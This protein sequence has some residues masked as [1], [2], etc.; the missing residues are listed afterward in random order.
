MSSATNGERENHRPPGLSRPH[1]IC[2][3][4][5]ENCVDNVSY[6]RYP[7]GIN[8][9]HSSLFVQVVTRFGAQNR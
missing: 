1:L 3:R 7:S 9:S 4:Q 6:L 8:F 2:S 5:V